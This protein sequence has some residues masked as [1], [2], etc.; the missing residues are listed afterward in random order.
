MGIPGIYE[1]LHIIL[2]MQIL[3]FSLEETGHL[4]FSANIL[5]MVEGFEGWEFVTSVMKDYSLI[6]LEGKLKVY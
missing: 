1:K 3:F 2:Y 5:E 6:N 4:K